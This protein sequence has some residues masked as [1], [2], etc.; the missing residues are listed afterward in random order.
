MFFKK[1]NLNLWNNFQFKKIGNDFL[2]TNDA[3]S[4]I[5]L[6]QKDFTRFLAGKIKKNEKIYQELKIKN[7]LKPNK[8]DL[9][10]LAS[11]YLR[12][13]SSV[14]RGPSL[15][16]LVLTLRCNHRCLYCHATPEYSLSRK[17]DM[18]FF[19]AKKALD[20]IFKTPSP[21][22]RIEF[23]GGEPLLNWKVLTFVVRRA[24][25]IN[26]KKK[27]NLKLSLVSNL[28]LL[29]EKKLKFLLDEGIDICCSFDGPAKVHNKNRI[30]LNSGKSYQIVLK[31]IKEIQKKNKGKKSKKSKNCQFKCSFNRHSLFPAL[32]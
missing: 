28:T 7:F 27:K 23:Q 25:I 3:G 8:K 4:W 5:L 17:F 20:L 32:F 18:N 2:L 30:Y 22:V 21:F 31:K 13:N 14:F 16:I 9:A 6:K 11:Q 15:F 24:K 12:L 10:A 29:D 26:R 1:I 19:V